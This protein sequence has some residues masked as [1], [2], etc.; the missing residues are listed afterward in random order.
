M[1]MSSED[2]ELSNAQWLF[3]RCSKVMGLP[4]TTLNFSVEILHVI[5]RTDEDDDIEVDLMGAFKETQRDM[6]FIF[7]I[8]ERADDLRDDNYLCEETLRAIATDAAAITK[9]EA[10]TNS[11]EMTDAAA[12]TEDTKMNSKA[13]SN[14]SSSGEEKEINPEWVCSRCKETIPGEKRY[15]C[16][17]PECGYLV[18]KDDGNGSTN[19][20]LSSAEMRQNIL[21]LAEDKIINTSTLDNHGVTYTEEEC[22]ILAEVLQKT[23]TL[24]VLQLGRSTA[25]RNEK[26]RNALGQNRTIKEL[27]LHYSGCDDA[28]ARALA[29]ALKSNET[30]HL[31]DLENNEITDSGAKELVAACL[32]K[33]KLAILNCNPVHENDG[34]MNY[35]WMYIMESI[36]RKDINTQP[37]P[38]QRTSNSSKRHTKER[39]TYCSP[40]CLPSNAMQ[41]IMQ[42][43]GCKTPP[44]DCEFISSHLK[45]LSIA[46]SSEY[47]IDTDLKVSFK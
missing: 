4:T 21:N 35:T 7:E 40:Y 11:D 22:E 20:P 25:L 6:A 29:V 15:F 16:H 17:C 47:N 46:A 8:L 1:N 9:E 45:N 38:Q 37:S 41:E 26:F 34:A 42:L 31:I 2:E 12:I 39:P 28:D 30:I 27:Y 33:K 32:I 44:V 18:S 19:P 13:S 36:A 23:T 5:K 14:S 3:N 43:A 24:E 10:S